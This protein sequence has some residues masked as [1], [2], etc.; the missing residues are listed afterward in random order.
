MELHETLKE[1]LVSKG[2]GRGRDSLM[3]RKSVKG[4]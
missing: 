3:F 1:T 2:T 4:V